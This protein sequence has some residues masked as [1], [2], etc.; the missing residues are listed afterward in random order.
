MRVLAASPGFSLIAV[1]TLA[2]GI[3]ANTSI[4]TVAN[5]ILLRPLP[6]SNPERL[7]FISRANPSQG[8]PIDV[9]SY[10]R[11]VFIRDNSKS[12]VGISAFTEESF[13]LTEAGDPEQLPAARVS[14]SFFRV[15]GVPLALGRDFRVEED[16]PSGKPVVV[17]SHRLWMRRYAG[18]PAVLGRSINLNAQSYTII[19]VAPA[20]FHFGLLSTDVQHLGAARLRSE[21]RSATADPGRR[22]ISECRG[23]PPSWHLD[24]SGAG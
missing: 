21:S 19:G 2:L 16:T 13:N 12:F 4:F 24:G 17:I 11:F 20:G 10:P 8:T 18:N 22:R 9:F 7:A 6:Y 3:G 1:L 14:A 23:A 15:L 5:A